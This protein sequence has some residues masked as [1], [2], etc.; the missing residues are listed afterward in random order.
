MPRLR[1]LLMV[2]FIGCLALP[3]D[4]QEK[5]LSEGGAGALFARSAF[6]HGYR[7]G[8]EEGYH[9][10]NLDINMGRAARSK[11]ALLHGLK[12]GYSPGYGPRRSF[13]SGFEAGL[14]AGYSD[15]F[16]G[17]VFRVIDSVREIAVPPPSE[18]AGIAFDQGLATGYREGFVNEGSPAASAL[19]LDFHSIGCGQFPLPVA[20]DQD[21]AAQG[22]YCDGYRRGF[23]L[24]HV[25]AQVLEAE[26]TTLEAS[27]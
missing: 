5:H 20:H 22:S 6:A 21:L 26:R 24:G 3:G 27:K 15:G 25:D 7:H 19:P 10:G 4:S 8:Y 16:T 14:V 11:K 18:A 13:E 12:Y 1:P 17:R 9:S 2:L 23:I